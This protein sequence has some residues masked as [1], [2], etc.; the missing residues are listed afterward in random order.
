[1]N[2]KIDLDNIKQLESIDSQKIINATAELPSQCSKALNLI[3]NFFLPPNFPTPRKI[4][5]LGTGGGSAVAGRLI[6]TLLF[7][8]LLCPITIHQGYNVPAWV[9][10]NTL[11]FVI[12][13]SGETEEIINAFK[14]VTIRRAKAIVITSGGQLSELSDT[15]NIPTVIFPANEMPA[16]SM[17]AYLFIPVLM[18]LERLGLIEGHYRRQIEEVIETLILI[19]NECNAGEL[20][21]NNP[22]KQIAAELYGK[23]PVI[24]GVSERTDVAALRWKNQIC[25]NSKILAHYNVFP[26]LNN[27]EIK[28]WDAPRGI[29]NYLQPV[30]L[31]ILM[32][33]QKSLVYKI[34]PKK[35]LK[36]NL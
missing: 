5:I 32:M 27:D 22:A 2:K 13:N 6:Y 31:R 16:R 30:F 33:M 4:F 9:D 21:P 18:I 35:L 17:I 7:N 15:C 26:D 3:Q 23:I 25:E 36:K 1:M 11:A 24:Y 12:S 34:K 8:D 14:Q 28:G 20:I 29:L 10:K 19:R